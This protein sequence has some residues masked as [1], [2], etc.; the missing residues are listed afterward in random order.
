MQSHMT[1]LLS[2]LDRKRFDPVVITPYS[3][4]LINIL[5]GMGIPAHIVPIYDR[6]SPLY[7]IKA[8]RSVAKII[9]NYR[10]DILHVHGHKAALIGRMATL[11]S[12]RCKI[13]STVH[14]FPSGLSKNG[15]K[16][17]IDRLIYGIVYRKG[18]SIAV[19]S[20]LESCLVREIGISEENVKVIP[21]GIDLKKWAPKKRNILRIKRELGLPDNAFLIGTAG[22]FVPF[23]G[24]SVLIDAMA[25][26]VERYE[27]AYLVL[28]G[29]GPLRRELEIQVE[30][31]GLSSR[32]RFAGFVDYPE[33]YI[34]AFNVFVL[35][36]LNE[37]FGIVVLEALAVGC[38]VVTTSAGG[39]VDI[40]EDGVSGRL[41]PPGDD[42]KLAEAIG[43]L[44]DNDSLREEIIANGTRLVNER[45]SI[46]LMAKRTIDVYEQCLHK[47]RKIS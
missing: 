41:V 20:A 43:E 4:S 26:I 28:L 38:P 42:N 7:D 46:D 33:E 1:G 30:R 36:S 16:K 29:E 2:R 15:I 11:L 9:D 39:V 18:Y 25:S 6:V 35:P 12:S 19:S 8:A 14:N 44:I 27:H 45:Y 3:E 17:H 21:N 10:P 37:P 5:S 47:R 23:K 31:L 32:V 40:I 13:I 22:R 24:H 34:S